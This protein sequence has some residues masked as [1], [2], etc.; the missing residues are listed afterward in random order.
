[1]EQSLFAALGKSGG[2]TNL[3]ILLLIIS[4][5]LIISHITKLNF[6]EF[7]HVFI[8]WIQKVF[9]KYI[10]KKE[11][12]YHR[13]LE[14]GKLSEKRRKVK[15]YKFLN[16][17]IIDLGLSQS[18]ITPYELFTIVIIL[19]FTAVS[20]LCKAFFGSFFMSIV[21]TPIACVATFCVMYTKANVAHDARI[22]AVF[23]A[24]NI[25]CNNIKVG[26]VV[27]VRESLDVIPKNIRPDF[28]D[29]VDNVEQK[30]YHIK[31]ALLELN[32]KLGSVSDEFIKKCI[33][34]ELDEEHGIAGMFSDIVELNN[35]NSNMRLDMKRKFEEVKHDFNI[36]G[37]MILTFLGAVLVIYTDVRNFYFTNIIGQ[38]LLALDALLFVLEYMYLT[39]LRA[40]EL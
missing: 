26:V 2:A 29:F 11:V 24:E 7:I 15:F 8:K 22:E 33:V 4:A 1:M 27:A 38:A 32:E 13:D 14:I 21:M 37:G 10:N 35:I 31:T 30:N 17:L 25:I 19:V 6:I 28:K 40:K 12:N 23:E 34:F 16:E 18:G 5:L 9:G 3:A 36:G 20:I 39:L